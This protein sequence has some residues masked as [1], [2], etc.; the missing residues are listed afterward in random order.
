MAMK[1]RSFSNEEYRFGF[2]GMEEDRDFGSEITDH[3]A[4]LFNKALGRWFACDP[5]E[6]KYPA[7]STFSFS[8][9]SPIMLKDSDGRE[10]E[11]TIYTGNPAKPD[12]F[13]TFK[14]VRLDNGTFQSVSADLAAKSPIAAQFNKV[15]EFL[16][17]TA[18]TTNPESKA[19]FEFFAKPLNENGDGIT[20]NLLFDGTLPFASKNPAIAYPLRPSESGEHVTADVAIDLFRA[21]GWTDNETGKTYCQSGSM[22]AGIHEVG[23]TF[24]M[25]MDIL[26]AESNGNRTFGL[27]EQEINTLKTIYNDIKAMYGN[28]NLI[29]SGKGE[30]DWEFFATVVQNF[31]AEGLGEPIIPSYSGSS[32]TSQTADY[33]E[34]KSQDVTETINPDKDE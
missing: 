4:R 12:Q 5:L 21:L 3:G 13:K 27:S 8:N 6:H 20:L 31:F 30:G 33:R 2:N 24:E 15:I 26:T 11:I 19:I 7:I 16:N 23:H 28:E 22:A 9:N 29:Y 25:F 32:D 10:F 34:V 18:S 14:V 17:Y 1:E